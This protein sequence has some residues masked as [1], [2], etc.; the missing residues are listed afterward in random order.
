MIKTAKAPGRCG[1]NAR[2]RV[3]EGRGLDSENVEEMKVVLII[4]GNH[5]FA[6]KT[7]AQVYGV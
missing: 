6:C 4:P 5:Q 2:N 1:A 7:L 3:E